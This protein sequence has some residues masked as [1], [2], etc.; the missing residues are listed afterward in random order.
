V[1]VFI[2]HRSWSVSPAH[3]R[4]VKYAKSNHACVGGSLRSYRK[5]LQIAGGSLLSYA[6]GDGDYACLPFA[7]RGSRP[8]GG[9]IGGYI[10]IYNSFASNT[11]Q[12][13]HRQF[14]L[15]DVMHRYLQ[16]E[17][18]HLYQGTQRDWW[19]RHACRDG[20]LEA[21][22]WSRFCNW[23]TAINWLLVC[24]LAMYRCKEK[25][26]AA[27]YMPNIDTYSSCPV[28]LYAQSHL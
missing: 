7:A 24:R 27:Y 15:G 26:L 22:G 1:E 21:E 9:R 2:V 4:S 20:A 13:R 18:G 12:R 8:G 16:R 23:L 25:K 10:R 19:P 14:S 3:R 6:S 11:D 17:R 28:G 5:H